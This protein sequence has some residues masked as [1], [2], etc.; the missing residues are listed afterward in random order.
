MSAIR[1]QLLGR[2][3]VTDTCFSPRDILAYISEKHKTFFF[4][5]DFFFFTV[6]PTLPRVV[7]TY[8]LRDKPKTA[9]FFQLCDR[10]PMS[11]LHAI[12]CNAGRTLD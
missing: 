7:F 4:I 10:N 12:Y 11:G 8:S 6:Y 2:L 3:Y 9:I 5:F 1:K